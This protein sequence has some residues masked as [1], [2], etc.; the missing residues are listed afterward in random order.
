MIDLA[1]V[2]RFAGEMV[3][4]ARIALGSLAP[5]I[6]RA[7]AAEEFLAD[8]ARFVRPENIN[9]DVTLGDGVFGMQGSILFGA[10]FPTRTFVRV[11]A[12][13]NLRFG[14]GGDLLVASLKAG[15]LLGRR[16][17][18]YGDVRLTYTLV[19]GDMPKTGAA[20][21]LFIDWVAVGG[22]IGPRYYGPRFYGPAFYGPR[23]YG[24]HVYVGPRAVIWR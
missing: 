6:V 5:T 9:D 8:P 18:L 20:T 13:Y 23:Y 10:S 2:V 24:P 19:E 1:I 3:E 12:G 14:D 16:V 4:Q 17:L 7:T 11:D 22:G 21:A 15:Q